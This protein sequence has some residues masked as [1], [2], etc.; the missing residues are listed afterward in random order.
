MKRSQGEA[1]EV[2]RN[3]GVME[4]GRTIYK[5]L[6]EPVEIREMKVDDLPGVLSIERVSFRTPWSESIFKEE[7]SSSLCRSLVATVGG[8]IAGYINFA[9]VSDE[10][11][12]R[13]VSVHKAFRKCGIASKLL[14]EMIRISSEAGVLWSTLEVRRSNTEAIKLYENFGFEIKGVRPSYYS[15]TREDAII[16]W[17]DLR[18]LGDLTLNG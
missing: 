15:D 16:M 4:I 13:N 1:V 18:N 11:H 8:E 14:S 2:K 17:A 7:L 6:S 3:A 5:I 12:L 9:I 10:V